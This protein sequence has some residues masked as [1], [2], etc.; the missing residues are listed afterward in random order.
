VLGSVGAAEISL[1]RVVAHADL[2]P[3]SC[4]ALPKSAVHVV[5]Q[6]EMLR[7]DRHSRLS[8]GRVDRL[9]VRLA[10]GQICLRLLDV[11]RFRPSRRPSGWNSACH[12][13]L[14]GQTRSR[15]S[16]SPKRTVRAP[17]G[18]RLDAKQPRRVGEH[19]PR[20]G[21]AETLALDTLRKARTCWGHVSACLT[22]AARSEVS[23]QPSI[24][25][26]FGDPGDAELQS[27]GDQVGRARSR[28]STSGFS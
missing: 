22:L 28:A 15:S 16:W 20:L 14:R 21:R 2:V 6:G 3:Q 23:G 17:L 11:Q 9:L 13:P 27:A 24:N 7:A 1:G 26:T 4:G 8:R 10:V 19:R 12:P 25:L 5:G 18:V